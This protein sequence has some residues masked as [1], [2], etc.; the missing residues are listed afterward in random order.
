MCS[1]ISKDQDYCLIEVFSSPGAEF[2]NSN[3][4]EKKFS[5]KV[6]IKN[7]SGWVALQQTY[8]FL[9]MG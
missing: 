3:L 2:V 1:S 5:L 7:L 6:A 9:R 4:N 8:N